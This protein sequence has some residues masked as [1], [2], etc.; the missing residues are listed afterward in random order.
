MSKSVGTTLKSPARTTGASASNRL[1]GMRDQPLEPCQLVV[2]LRP[3]LGVA[4]REVEAGDQD[5]VDGGF[6]VAALIV[7]L[8]ARQGASRDHRDGVPRQDRDAVPGS[9][10][11]PHRVVS[12]PAQ[13]ER[14]EIVGRPP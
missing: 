11:L 9:L 3:R 10:A 8:V 14:A 12:D 13:R 4:V 5:A 6:D 7:R 1:R 2:E